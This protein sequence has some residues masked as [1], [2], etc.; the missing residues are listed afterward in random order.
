MSTRH[1]NSGDSAA[2]NNGFRC[3]VRNKS[4]K[5]ATF[6]IDDGHNNGNSDD[7]KRVLEM[8]RAKEGGTGVMEVERQYLEKE[9]EALKEEIKKAVKEEKEKRKKQKNANKQIREE[10]KKKW[11]EDKQKYRKDRQEDGHEETTKIEL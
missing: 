9:R 2:N 11:D 7:K 5:K 10:G 1:I 3:I 6:D 4:V 8:K